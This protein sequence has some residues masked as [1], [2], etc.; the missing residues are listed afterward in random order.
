MKHTTL[1]KAFPI[2]AAAI[3]ERFGIQVAIGGDQAYT[4][5]KMIQL[6]AYN[7]NDPNYHTVAWG[8]L[9]HEAAHIRYSDFTLDYGTSELRR[10][11]A[12]AIEDV[13]IEDALA[14]EFPGTR[15]TLRS[16]VNYMI[17][18]GKFRSYTTTDH[19]ANVLYGYVL[20]RL[21][22]QVLG[23]IA[24]QPLLTQNEQVLKS[25]FPP[26][27]MQE[28]N[29]LLST[30]PNGLVS[31]QDSMDLADRIF[32]MLNEAELPSN[33]SPQ[34]TVSPTETEVETEETADKEA[35]GDSDSNNQTVSESHVD[36]DPE[37]KPDIEIPKQ[38]YTDLLDALSTA[39][40]ADIDQDV[41]E[42][43]KEA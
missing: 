32:T 35:E 14:N 12:G 33:D 9:A 28:L 29:R 18:Q 26:Q 41:F 25:L 20:K 3:G 39:D 7:G 4:D 11:L 42:T 34:P 37:S 23:Q 15:L 2:V 24:L 1:H 17:D 21:R 30:V 27:V 8:L 22:V 6:P 36:T 19:P 16:V 40:A 10:R 43:L 5:G 38:I 13:R 31:E